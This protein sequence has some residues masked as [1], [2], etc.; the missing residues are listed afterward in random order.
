QGPHLRE[1]RLD[2]SHRGTT[3][4]DTRVAP[5]RDVARR[6]ANPRLS[7]AETTDEAHGAVHAEHLPMIPAEPAPRT[8]RRPRVVAADL[9]PS[10]A[11]P[12]GCRLTPPAPRGR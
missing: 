11:R 2:L 3:H 1:R 4:F 7:D 8:R 12:R 6:V 5:R 10:R 9:D